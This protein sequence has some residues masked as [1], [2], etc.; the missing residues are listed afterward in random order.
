MDVGLRIGKQTVVLKFQLHQ[1]VHLNTMLLLSMNVMSIYDRFM[2]CW[3][4]FVNIEPSLVVGWLEVELL[5]GLRLLWSVLCEEGDS[6]VNCRNRVDCKATR[7][8]MSFDMKC[9][10]CLLYTSPSPRDGLLSRMPSSA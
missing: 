7:G 6:V 4:V 10:N 2:Y 1:L 5:S 9:L 3:F 8:I